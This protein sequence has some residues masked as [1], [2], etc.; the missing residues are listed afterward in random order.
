MLVCTCVSV[1]RCIDSV[2]ACVEERERDCMYVVVWSLD[3][4][5]RRSLF[6]WRYWARVA[7]LPITP[8]LLSA[9]S[10]LI[11]QFRISY[12]GQIIE[13]L[14]FHLLF[15]TWFIFSQVDLVSKD[16]V[17]NNIVL[18]IFLFLSR[19]FNFFVCE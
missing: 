17:I 9:G 14:I 7:G 15:S 16:I 10:C 1:Y 19:Q 6:H 3:A 5:L 12:I 8:A 2:Y 13:F 4:V 11:N 18:G